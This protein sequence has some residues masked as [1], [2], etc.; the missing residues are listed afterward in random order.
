VGDG[1]QL[2]ALNP[3]GAVSG[4]AGSILGGAAG[5]VLGSGA[6]AVFDAA[7]QWVATGAVWLL[8]QIGSVMSQTTSVGLDTTWF[9]THEAVM[10]TLAAGL[11]LPMACVGAIQAIY[12][13]N[14]GVLA[15]SFLVNLPLALLFTGV[16]VQLVQLGLALTDSM[17][18][19]VLSAGGVDTGHLFDSVSEF[20]GSPLAAA[21]GAPPFVV[22]AAAILVAVSA[23]TLWLELVVRAASVSAAVLFL[24]MAL[25]T[26]VWPAVSHWCRRLGETIAALVLSKFVI[27]AVLSLA[28]GA[29]AGGLGTEGSGGGGAAAAVTGIALLLIATLCPFA[30]LRIVPAVEAGAIAHLESVRHRFAGAAR[31]VARAGFVATDF[32][33]GLAADAGVAGI[34]GDVGVDSVGLEEGTDP[35][36]SGDVPGVNEGHPSTGSAAT[37]ASAPD[38]AQF[39]TDG[40]PRNEGDPGMRWA[41]P[42]ITGARDDAA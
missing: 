37:S 1:V 38:T 10:A 35:S 12:R 41:N 8:G 19:R 5:S 36:T 21:T 20:L 27:A 24:P 2:V 16:A 31:N 25:A 33:T 14:P 17:S 18:R 22:F 7:S 29:L 13:Q 23:I 15:R 3:V 9:R 11:V 39:G 34:E 28:A 4:A 26:L 40:T 30:L 42:N 6:S 32:V